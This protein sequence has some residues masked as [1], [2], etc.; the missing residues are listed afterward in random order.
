M[1]T[2]TA[3]AP[4][5]AIA[6]INPFPHDVRTAFQSYIQSSEYINRERIPYAKWQRMHCFI[7]DST[8]KAEGRSDANLKHRALA[9]FQL[10][11][12]KLYKNPDSRF[13]EPRLVVPESEAFDTIINEHLQLLHAGRTKTWSIIQQKYY[14]LKREEIEFILKRCKNCALNRPATTR[15]PLVPIV[16]STAWERV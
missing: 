6:S 1:A 12:N 13:P 2:A 9:E 11:N 14:G 5:P 16:T 15:A 8:L 4:A 7:N 3:T 10:I